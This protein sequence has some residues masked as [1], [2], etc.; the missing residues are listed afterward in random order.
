MDFNK[1][2]EDTQEVTLLIENQRFTANKNVLCEYSDYF[3]AMFSGNYIENERQEIKID[4]VDA[5]SMNMILQYMR[6]GLIDLSEYSLTTI[7]ELSIAANFLQ[8]TE[9]IKQIEYCLD[10][11]L[12]VS[13]WMETMIIAENSS[14]TKLE[15]LSAAF[16]L[17]NFKQMKKEYILNIHR[18]FWYLSHPYLD[19]DNE[20]EVFRFGYEWII[21]SETGADAILIVL[22]CLDIQ[23][24]SHNDIKEIKTLIKDFVDSLPLKVVDCILEITEHSELSIITLTERKDELC[25][26]FT[27]RVYI[28]VFK[29]VSASVNRKLIFTPTV[30]VW[31]VKDTKPEL[32]SHHMYTFS[33]DTGL[34][35][36]L[37]VAEKNLWGWNVVAWGANKLVLVCGEHGRGTSVF[38]KDVKVYDTFRKEWIL[39]G[40]EL[41]SRRHGGVAIMGDSLFIIGGVG[42]FRVVLDTA[43][44]YD[45]KQRTHRKIAKLPDTI[46]NPA[47]CVHNN[48]IY[49][50][51][52]K[53]IYQY[54]DLGQTDRWST[55]ILTDIR[56]NCMTS[57]NNY[58][59]CTQNYF[60][61]LY[62]FRPGI[63]TKLQLI[64]YFTNP[65]AAIC[66]LGSK[67][68]FFT[69]PM[70]GQSD[71]LAAEEYKGKTDD[72]MPNVLWSVSNS[73]IKV[74]DVAGSCTL[75]IN[76]PPT[77][78]AISQYHKRYL[79]QY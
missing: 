74:N 58:I 57:F 32:I 22:G 2:M 76:I 7:G 34:E 6:I 66:H 35:K 46:Q 62:R 50:S 77:R 1:E 3:R 69:R 49:V 64:T 25:E 18:L 21:N 75:V 60:S 54:E 15:Q 38:M 51:G 70:C 19:T 16:G 20:L 14:Y 33:E 44:I 13:N 65:P 27:A 4:M 31:I 71:T 8:I 28:E 48:S 55:V 17:L 78:T 72:E 61:H 52:Q 63:D 5:Y 39:H 30:P 36:W 79:S 67:L 59:Y 41:P 73:K 53:N 68:L 24:L 43:V 56:P 29:L 42:G 9:L 12:S 37:E 11:Q 47:V 23:R 10:L 26:K 40:V 45:L